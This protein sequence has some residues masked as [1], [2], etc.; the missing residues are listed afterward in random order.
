MSQLINELAAAGQQ[1][2]G[3]TLEEGTVPRLQAYARSV[4][5]FPTAVKEVLDCAACLCCSSHPAV[6][7]Q[8]HVH[9]FRGAT[10]GFT[11]SAPLQWPLGVQTPARRTLHGSRRLALYDPRFSKAYIT[12]LCHMGHHDDHNYRYLFASLPTAQRKE[13]MSKSQQRLLTTPPVVQTPPPLQQQAPPRLPRSLSARKTA[14]RPCC[15]RPT[16]ERC[17]TPGRR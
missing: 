12:S 5:H 7:D 3:V 2:L 9:S 16:A 11:T 6:T 14:C 1:A 17:A 4:A 13:Y 10:A 8:S 15:S